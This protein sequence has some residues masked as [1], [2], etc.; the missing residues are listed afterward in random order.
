MRAR[1][2][3]LLTVYDRMR[4]NLEA[5]R[6]RMASAHGEAK[7]EDGAVR[8][9]V[10]PRGDLRTLEIGPRAYRRLSPSELADEILTLA[11]KAI[12]D[13]QAQLEEVMSPF[14]PAGMSYSDVAAG[15][16]DPAAWAPGR[17]PVGGEDLS[18]WLAGFGLRRGP[19]ADQDASP[20]QSGNQRKAD[21]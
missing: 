13:V 17:P 16:V 12:T 9:T 7:S 10:G 1:F 2:E 21:T 15:N 4:G 3:E 20:D 11:G 5:M 19:G 8:L 18:E 14:L 6:Q